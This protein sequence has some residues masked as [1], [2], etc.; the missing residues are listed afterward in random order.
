MTLTTIC[1]TD[2]HI[3]KGDVP[4]VTDGRILGHEGVGVVEVAL[5]VRE[6][7]GS[8]GLTGAVKTSGSRGLHVYVPKEMLAARAVELLGVPAE[9]I[10]PALEQEQ[11]AVTQ[12]IAR[13]YRALY[14]EL[15]ASRR[16]A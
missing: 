12:F 3:L 8:L 6:E 16:A 10:E 14:E 9:L 7:L 11:R 13:R 5:L 4:A 2:L 15:A 1:G